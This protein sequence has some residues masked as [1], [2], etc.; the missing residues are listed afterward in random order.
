MSAT[1]G[2]RQR[3]GKRAA[4][5]LLAAGAI[6]AGIVIGRHTLAES[7]QRLTGLDWTWFLAAIACEFISLIAFGLSRRRLLR[8]DGSSAHFSSVMAITYASNALSMTIPF[9]GAQLAVVFSYQQFR[10]RGLG[11]AITSWALAVSAILSTSALAVLLVAG[12][13][14][15]GASVATVDRVRRRGPALA[16]GRGRPAGPARSAGAP[17]AE[18]GPGPAHHL[19]AA[20]A[21]PAAGRVTR[22]LL[23][24]SWTG[25]PASG[26][27]GR[28]TR[29]CSGWRC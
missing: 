15:G 10:R 1:T 23:R 20:P 12:S 29:R 11:Q 28:G 18:R 27:R 14:A 25:W 13:L 24:R 26:C 8:A 4:V 6:T 21:P 2:Q 3:N 19:R 16:A 5:V 9:A 17:L 7:L 22:A